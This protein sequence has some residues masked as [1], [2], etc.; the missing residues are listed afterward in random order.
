MAQQSPR[1][2]APYVPRLGAPNP[3]KRGPGDRNP[4]P[5]AQSKT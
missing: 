2:S 1:A 5:T 3:A 4:P